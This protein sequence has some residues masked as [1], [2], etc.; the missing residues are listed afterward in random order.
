MINRAC[1]NQVSGSS[2][3]LARLRA[4][5]STGRRKMKHIRRRHS[6]PSFLY[7]ILPFDRLVELFEQRELSLS[8]PSCW[9]D[10]Y[11]SSLAN[12]AFNSVFAQCWCRVGISDAMWRIYSPDRFSVRIKTTPMLLREQ[13]GLALSDLDR[14]QWEISRVS[15]TSTT[16]DLQSRLAQLRRSNDPKDAVRSLFTKRRAFK[17]EAEYRL[18]VF[19]SCAV[20]N[21]DRLVIPVDP[22]ALVLSVLADPRATDTMMQVFKFYLES[23]LKFQGQVGKSQLYQG[24]S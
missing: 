7:R 16:A 14:F 3:L 22:H 18:A 13:V 8:R 12:E 2:H 9:D 19:D 4:W 15:Y 6:Q 24:V 10:P 17:H 11:E 5:T 1:K 21:R 23:K 20:A